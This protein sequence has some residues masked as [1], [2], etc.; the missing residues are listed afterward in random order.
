M[1]LDIPI[2]FIHILIAVVSA[3]NTFQIMKNINMAIQV[4]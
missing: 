3:T 4:V 2:Q 1:H